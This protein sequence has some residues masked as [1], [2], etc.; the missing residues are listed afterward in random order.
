MT[1]EEFGKNLIANYKRIANE[2]FDIEVEDFSET[3]EELLLKTV[4]LTMHEWLN[5]T[6]E[7]VPPLDDP[8]IIIVQDLSK[9][10]E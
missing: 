2:D 1:F 8:V 6:L 5:T 7:S 9:L 3:D 4:K 10:L